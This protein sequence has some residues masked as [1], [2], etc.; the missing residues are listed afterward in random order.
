MKLITHKWDQGY[1]QPMQMV[2]LPSLQHRRLHLKLQH[3]FHII[4]G[5]CNFPSIFQETTSYCGGVQDYNCYISHLREQMHSFIRL[6]RVVQL[7]GTT[8]LS[9]KLL[10]AAYRLLKAT[11]LTIIHFIIILYTFF[12]NFVYCIYIIFVSI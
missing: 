6:Y 8:S 1:T 9:C 7:H 3:M 4:H 10:R 11:A 2:D 12:I 5:L